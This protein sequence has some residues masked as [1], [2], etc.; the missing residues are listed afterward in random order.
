MEKDIETIIDEMRELS[1]IAIRAAGEGR[2]IN[3][4]NLSTLLDSWRFG[5]EKLKKE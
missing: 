2:K 5:L 4:A 3:L 1:E